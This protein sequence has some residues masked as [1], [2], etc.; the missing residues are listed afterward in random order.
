MLVS[1]NVIA[2]LMLLLML[3]LMLFMLTREDIVS[4][5]LMYYF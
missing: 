5:Y 1:S 3:L 4:N 2:M